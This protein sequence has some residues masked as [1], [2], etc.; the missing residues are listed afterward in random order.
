[1]LFEYFNAIFQGSEVLSGPHGAQTAM[2]LAGVTLKSRSFLHHCQHV[3]QQPTASISSPNY[4]APPPVPSSTDSPRFS[5]S[6][7]KRKLHDIAYNSYAGSSA[8]SEFSLAVKGRVELITDA[9]TCWHCGA[10]PTDICR[11]MI[12]KKDRE[13]MH[14]D[15][16]CD[17][18]L[19]QLIQQGLIT[20]DHL[21]HIDNAIPLYPTCHRNLDDLNKPGLIFLPSRLKYFI[22]FER[23]DY[24]HRV[25]RAK[26]TGAIP[27]R[28]CP[29]PQMYY[30]HQIQIGDLQGQDGAC[31]G[32]YLRYTL[33]D[34]FPDLGQRKS[35]IR[36]RGPF[37]EPDAWHGA[38]MATIW[39]AFS[40]PRKS[41]MLHPR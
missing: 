8:S 2:N 41:V 36:D 27:Q 37:Q 9:E 26:D 4:A 28:T 29:N 34:Y 7:R 23:E 3:C 25:I 20:F 1:M 14:F 10:R 40:R 35:W 24:A 19:L 15:K 30:E 6:G 32:L 39:R 18:A 38:P 31:G 21:G 22:N 5:S 17:F 33:Y 13:V 11:V 16:L 12:G